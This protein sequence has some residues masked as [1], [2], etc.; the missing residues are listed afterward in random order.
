M[1]LLPPSFS[2]MAGAPSNSDSTTDSGYQLSEV[3]P[4]LGDKKKRFVWKKPVC[5]QWLLGS[6]LVFSRILS[7][8]LEVCG[9]PLRFSITDVSLALPLISHCLPCDTTQSASPPFEPV[10]EKFTYRK[11]K[12]CCSKLVQTPKRAQQFLTF[13][14]DYRAS[15]SLFWC[16]SYCVRVISANYSLTFWQLLL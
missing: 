11:R 9:C 3:T 8:F 10:G 4:L 16:I 6:Y 13:P 7:V 1:V 5:T 2:E 15:P 12:R 14:R